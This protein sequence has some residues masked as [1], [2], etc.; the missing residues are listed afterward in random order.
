MKKLATLLAVV[1]LAAGV[2]AGPADARGPQTFRARTAKIA[3]DIAFGDKALVNINNMSMWFKR[4]GY[5]AG[6]PYTDNS[7]LSYPRST[8]NAIYRDG[9]VWGGRVIDG[10]DQM[11]RVG[12]STYAQG[13]VPGRIISK[14]VADDAADPRVRIYRV[15]RDWK[16]ADLRLETAEYLDIGLSEVTDA[17]VAA[18]RAQYGKDWNE[19]PT[20]WGAPYYDKNGDGAYDPNVDEPG[21][22]SADQVAW[23]VINDLDVGA[24][25][26]LYGALPI[27]MECQVLMWGYARTDALGDAI[28]KKFTV[29][30]KGTKDTPDDARIDDMYFAQWSDPDLGDSGDDF[31]G[32]DTDLSLGYVY[33]STDRDARYQ[34][35]NM[36]PPAIGYD[37]LQGPT[38]PVYKKDETGAV[39][40]DDNGK[41]VLDETADAIFNFQHR[42]GYKNLPMTA[43][44][45]FA[46]GSSINDPE[47]N[48]YN[49]TLQW[50][51]LLRGYE[52]QPDVENPTPF[53]DPLT[54]EETK[55]TLNGDP[56]RATGWT[57]GT[58]LP[59]GDRR[60]VLATG[61]FSMA[62]GDT[63]EVVVAVVGGSS[64]DRLRSIS[65]MKFNDQFVQDAYNSLFEV[66]KAPT[67]PKV[68]VAE[69]DGAVL[70]DWGW[71]ATAV[72][73]TEMDAQGFA[74][75]GYNLYQLPSAEAS[76]AQATKLATFD[77]ENGVATIQGISLDE[78]SGVVLS[79][80]LQ[81]GTDAGVR[82]Y[83]KITKD[84]LRGTPL[85]NGQQYYFA[86][87]AY[88][89]NTAEGAAVT[90]LESGLQVQVC[91]PQ[92]PPPGT[93]YLSESA[94]ILPAGHPA[95]ASDGTVTAVVVDPTH[96]TGD[97]Y[98]VGFATDDAGATTWSLTNAKTN[99]TLLTGQA[100][101]TGA[102]VYVG[103]EGFEV[104]VSGPPLGMKEWQ[105][106]SGTRW[107]TFRGGDWGAE[108]F[109]PESGL[110]GAITGDVN[111]QWFT[112]STVPAS[113]LKTVKLVFSNVI[114]DEGE[115]QFHP[116]DLTN[117]NVSYAYR[118]LRRAS[119]PAPAPGDLTSTKV[120]YDWTKYLVNPAAG[121]S[122]QDR[123]PICVSAW[124]MESNPPRRLEVGFL[125][126]NVAGGL[127]N[128]AWGPAFYNSVSNIA[129]TG[130]REWL[131]VFDAD[132]TADPAAARD[133]L[134]VDVS[135]EPTPLMWIVFAA[136]RGETQFPKDGDSF[137]MVANH[138]NSPADQFTFTVPGTA[139][140]DSLA[141]ADVKLINVFPNPYYG[142]NE[143]ETSPYQKFVTFSHL[144]TQA[145]IRIYDLSGSL[146]RKLEKDDP[147]QFLRWDLNNDNALPVASGLYIVHI[148][149]PGVNKTKV[150]KLAI[151]QEQQFL[152][153]F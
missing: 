91:V 73:Q 50:Y 100:D 118:Y 108:G 13:C 116:A 92:A 76:M 11:L 41:P 6:N 5:T 134:K 138:V 89:R 53:T 64:T 96:T 16:T 58:P 25:Q 101:Q 103:S 23:F 47:L 12:G 55:F 83:V 145:V 21:V 85:V 40:L 52:P 57:D 19:W 153:N 129:G 141:A 31:A 90:T 114:Q 69:L 124:D 46:A 105:I 88:N 147:E 45:Y 14:G 95:G 27:G 125:E 111:N 68:R 150:L 86:V 34:A 35:F 22:A 38:V 60:I 61:P 43:F 37:F 127:V 151:V 62:L 20:A 33:N 2:L 102:G 139:S 106:P 75:E 104:Q 135:G 17:E 94:Q 87:T 146:V 136:R 72:A 148:E 51:N 82:R 122:Y 59:P 78:K 70:L 143:A 42:A 54:G 24:S 142:V 121:Y 126:N 29:I 9:L 74:F 93:R 98:K 149:L 77:L 71:D 99:R 7:G 120:P 128:G 110:P 65:K 15:R 107:L 10:K 132:Y 131:F 137:L 117:P 97:T 133:E 140:S 44:V 67:T 36:A 18:V 109:G 115:T 63:Q 26:A 113:A 1:A 28:F 152:E 30:Y 3:Q 81:I 48:E 49:G 4:D 8:D 119:Q 39:V 112:T 80:P 84:I 66:P 56:V 79:V 32:C 130:P 144:P 123:S